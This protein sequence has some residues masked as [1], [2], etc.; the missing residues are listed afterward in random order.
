[1]SM[2]VKPDE[3]WQACPPSTLTKMASHERQL[4]RRQFLK[5]VGG[6]G[7]VIGTVLMGAWLLS[8]DDNL[9]DVIGLPSQGGFS[10]EKT[11]GGISCTKVKESAQAFLQAR[12]GDSLVEQIEVHLEYCVSCKSFVESLSEANQRVDA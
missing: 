9:S 8:D 11:Y 4:Q 5:R 3:G 1:M 10:G 2:N 12:L 7:G 6:A